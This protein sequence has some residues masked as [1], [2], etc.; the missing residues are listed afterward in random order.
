VHIIYSTQNNCYVALVKTEC[1]SD[2]KMHTHPNKCMCVTVCL[3][4]QAWYIAFLQGRNLF[5]KKFPLV[6]LLHYNSLY[7]RT[8]FD[9]YHSNNLFCV[10]GP[11]H[12]HVLPVKISERRNVSMSRI[13]GH[14]SS[15][16][17][18]SDH[19]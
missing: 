15:R 1:V 18:L 14:I 7:R 13:C 10:K 8:Q 16:T 3:F 11:I 2:S 6:E 5:C 19:L 9:W 12:L 17:G 4:H